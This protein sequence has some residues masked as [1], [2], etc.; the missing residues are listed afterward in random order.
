M[1]PTLTYRNVR[2]RE[3]TREAQGY[4]RDHALYS[5]RRLDN[6]QRIG[7]RG[8]RMNR[9]LELMTPT[10]LSG[11]NELIKRQITIYFY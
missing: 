7:E 5:L 9:L 3:I 2:E 4:S 6:G 1:Y 11:V 8:Q 10:D